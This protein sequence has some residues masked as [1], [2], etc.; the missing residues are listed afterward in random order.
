MHPGLLGAVPE[1]SEEKKDIEAAVNAK[2]DRNTE[3]P[4]IVV[5]PYTQNVW[6]EDSDIVE[7]RHN[8]NDKFRLTWAGGIEH[9]IRGDWQQARDVF[10]ETMRLSKGKDGPSKFL[11]DIIDHHGGTAPHDWP[12]YRTEGGGH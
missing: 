4:T 5:P 9:Y 3:A 10:H 1:G 7:L 12:G 8:I 6:E 11:M 2:N